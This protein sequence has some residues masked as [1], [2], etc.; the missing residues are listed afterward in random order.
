MTTWGGEL[1][2]D[3]DGRAH[4]TVFLVV[5]ADEVEDDVDA[6]EDEPDLS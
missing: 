5:T 4:D 6:D 2:R 1:G 3:S